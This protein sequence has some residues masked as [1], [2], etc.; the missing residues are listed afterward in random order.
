[1]FRVEKGLK[2]MSHQDESIMHALSTETNT[3]NGTCCATYRK[4]RREQQDEMLLTGNSFP[5]LLTC[6]SGVDLCHHLYLKN[7][8][9][10]HQLLH[11]WDFHHVLCRFD[12]RMDRERVFHRQNWTRVGIEHKLEDL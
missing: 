6:V 8:L 4:M 5:R 12:K 9:S 2:R 11:S 10:D 1:M 7:F 3:D